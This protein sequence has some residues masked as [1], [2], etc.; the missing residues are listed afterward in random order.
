MYLLYCI[1]T[2]VQQVKKQ[3][4]DRENATKFGVYQQHDCT[5]QVQ[6]QYSLVDS[7]L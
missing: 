5:E 2:I 4:R 3:V 1:S 6:S 7:Y